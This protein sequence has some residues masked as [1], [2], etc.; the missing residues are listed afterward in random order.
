MADDLAER[1]IDL[2]VR[3]AYQDRAVAALDE[4]VRELAARVAAAE[5]ELARMRAAAAAP[6]GGEPPT[7]GD[8][9]PEEAP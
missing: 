3:L 2:E 4:V 8:G 1:L 9:E 5:A 7:P 6:P